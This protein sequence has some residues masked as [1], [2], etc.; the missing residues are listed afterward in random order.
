MA[1]LARSAGRAVFSRRTIC[2]ILD[3][4]NGRPV[5]ADCCCLSGL[6][7]RYH[8]AV[9]VLAGVTLWAFDHNKRRVNGCDYLFSKHIEDLGFDLVAHSII[10]SSVQSST[11][12]FGFFFGFRI[13]PAPLKLH[14]ISSS[15]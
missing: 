12:I 6:G 2:A 15:A 4:G 5:H 9:A 1:V 11:L 14:V 10:S 7:G 8:W 13:L 3:R